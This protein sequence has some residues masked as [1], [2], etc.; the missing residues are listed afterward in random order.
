MLIL[1]EL[2][3]RVPFE[4]QEKWNKPRKKKAKP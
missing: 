1:Q 4:E 2:N 3:G